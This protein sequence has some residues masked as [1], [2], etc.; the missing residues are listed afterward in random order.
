MTCLT[1]PAITDNVGW[2]CFSSAN[3]DIGRVAA[4]NRNRLQSAFART[5]TDR[6]ENTMSKKTKALKKDIK[7]TKNKV[8]KQKKKLKKLRKKLKKAS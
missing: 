8:A 3:S 6:M 1:T 7:A 4:Y 5:H 2:F